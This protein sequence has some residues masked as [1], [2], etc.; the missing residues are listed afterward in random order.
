MY[1]FLR[2]SCAGSVAAGAP[3]RCW[4]CRLAAARQ[5]RQ[6]HSDRRSGELSSSIITPAAHRR[7]SLAQH[8]DARKN[9]REGGWRWSASP[10]P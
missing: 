9:S 7:P 3:T 2:S 5:G 8:K 10:A 1:R 4:R 6:R